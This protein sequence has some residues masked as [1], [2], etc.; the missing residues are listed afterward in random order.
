MSSPLFFS[1][2]TWLA[3]PFLGLVLLP[4]ITAT[5]HAVPFSSASRRPSLPS[6]RF[7]A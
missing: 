6:R 2:D 3:N 1:I 4:Q 7:W 5:M